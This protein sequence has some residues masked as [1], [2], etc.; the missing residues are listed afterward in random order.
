MEIK[1]IIFKYIYL[2]KLKSIKYFLN[3]NYSPIYLSII[4]LRYCL[5]FLYIYFYKIIKKYIILKVLNIINYIKK[6]I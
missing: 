3:L 4:Y 1:F 6:I 2:Y 5:I